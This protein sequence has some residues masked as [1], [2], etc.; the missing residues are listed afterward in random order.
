MITKGDEKFKSCLA[1]IPSEVSITS[2]IGVSCY[3][4]PKFV[5]KSDAVSLID[6]KKIKI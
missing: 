1:I 3:F 5:Y 6:W 4:V 2:Q